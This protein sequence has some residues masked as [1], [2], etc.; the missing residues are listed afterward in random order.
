MDE[1]GFVLALAGLI[2][3]PMCS[4]EIEQ[5]VPEGHWRELVGAAMQS[6]G[7]KRAEETTAGLLAACPTQVGAGFFISYNK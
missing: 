4:V 7:V 6:S 1:A 3:D 2:S 5:I